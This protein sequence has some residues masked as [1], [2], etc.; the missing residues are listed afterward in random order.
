M[1]QTGRDEIEDGQPRKVA[2]LENDVPP[3]TRNAEVQVE[4]AGQG[5]DFAP[6]TEDVSRNGYGPANAAVQAESSASEPV[7]FPVSVTRDGGAD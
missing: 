3:G 4:L 2:E 1:V 5:V 6:D 7:V